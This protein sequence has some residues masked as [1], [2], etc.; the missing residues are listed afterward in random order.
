METIKT[1]LPKPNPQVVL[2]EIIIPE[3]LLWEMVSETLD[4]PETET[5]HSMIG[6]YVDGKMYVLG[7]FADPTHA[8]RHGGLFGRGG[9]EL[10]EIYQWLKA[11]WEKRRR[12]LFTDWDFGQPVPNGVIPSKLDGPL[13]YLGDWHRHPGRMTYPSSHDEETALTIVHNEAREGVPILA[14]IVTFFSPPQLK[15]RWGEKDELIL[16]SQD[17][18][19]QVDWYYLSPDLPGGFGWRWQSPFKK[20]KVVVVA[21]EQLPQ[22]APLPWHLSDPHR[23][24]TEIGLLRRAGYQV[25]WKTRFMSQK[26]AMMKIVIALDHPTW[27]KKVVAV[28]R[29]NY[30]E[31]RVEFQFFPKRKP[32]VVKG[33]R[34]AVE[35]N[36]I[37]TFLGNMRKKIADAW[38]FTFPEQ[39]ETI[40]DW[41]RRDYRETY[42]IDAVHRL[43]R[44]GKVYDP[45]PELG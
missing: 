40:W 22:L 12:N 45:K 35:P 8:I 5:G 9:N 33:P 19:L 24:Q 3:S 37:R 16:T 28:T 25:G 23:F 4:H 21:D 17:P 1:A 14:P 11:H 6:L 31:S 7:S 27:D 44:E 32:E 39:E 34:V 15:H 29:W 26:D 38:E 43:E 41:R 10:V 30:P 36:P 18:E 42:L 20:V 13:W 2:P